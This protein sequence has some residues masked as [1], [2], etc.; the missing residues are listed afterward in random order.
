MINVGDNFSDESKPCRTVG[1]FHP[2]K[3]SAT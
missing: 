1:K 3:V 2:T